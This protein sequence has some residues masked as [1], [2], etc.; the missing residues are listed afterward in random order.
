MRA[1]TS[2]SQLTGIR[3]EGPRKHSPGFSLGLDLNP[4]CALKGRKNYPTCTVLPPLRGLSR[5][6]WNSPKLKPG[7]I[8]DQ[9]TTT[10]S[11]LHYFPHAP[12]STAELR[13]VGSNE[14]T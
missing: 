3:P 10:E 12:I 6:G 8:A 1:R 2:G 5:G 14:A 11:I 4:M 9:L 13:N 7:P